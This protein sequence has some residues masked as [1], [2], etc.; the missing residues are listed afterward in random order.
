MKEKAATSFDMDVI[1]HV[2]QVKLL[3]A[4]ACYLLTQSSPVILRRA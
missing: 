3:L 2:R 4:R 1:K